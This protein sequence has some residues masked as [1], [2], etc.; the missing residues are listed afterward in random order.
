LWTAGQAYFLRNNGNAA[1]AVADLDPAQFFSRF[2]M[3]YYGDC[4]L[5][6]RGGATPGTIGGSL[7]NLI[8]VAQGYTFD[9]T[10][11]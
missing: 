2:G 11:R 6:R 1:G 8:D 5:M 4:R 7:F 3:D 10:T 9:P